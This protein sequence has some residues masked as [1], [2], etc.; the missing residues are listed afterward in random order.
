MA[1]ESELERLSS[2]LKAR[3]SRVDKLGNELADAIQGWKASEPLQWE[4]VIAKDRLSWS[5]RV[6]CEQ[7]PFDEWSVIFSDAI[8]QLRTT[9][10]NLAW[11]LAH[12]GGATPRKPRAI[13]FPIVGSLED[14][15]SEAKRIAELSAVARVA[16]ESV[17]P[18]Q[19]TGTGNS[20]EQDGLLLLSRLNNADKHR[21]LLQPSISPREIEHSFQVMFRN[22]DEAAANGPPDVTLS[23]DLFATEATLVL[24]RTK[25]PIESVSGNCAFG[26]QVVLDDSVHGALG[27]TTVLAQLLMYVPM[28]LD[29][30]L[31]AV[32]NEA[33]R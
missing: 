26:A 9:L 19:R 32:A 10:D 27:V 17:Q 4:T 15:P 2:S 12:L 23:A 14:W 13:Q 7:P 3:L 33:D 11:G 6:R 8:H 31:I 16:I 5:L 20:P 22:D 25:T 18:F 21:I 24:H 28:V 30:V 29:R 1:P